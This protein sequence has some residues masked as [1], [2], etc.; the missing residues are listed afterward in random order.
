MSIERDTRQQ[1]AII[2]T[3]AEWK[4]FKVVAESYL[5][6][7]ACLRKKHLR[8]VPTG[9]RLLARNSQKRLLIGVAI[10]QLLKAVYLQKGYCI[11]VL[12]DGSGPLQWPYT[13]AQVQAGGFALNSDK[14]QELNECI[15]QLS[16]NV[17]KLGADREIVLEGLRIAKVYRNK[18]AHIVTSTHHY[19]PMEYRKVEAALKLL[20]LH[21]FNQ[22]LELHFSIS[23]GEKPRFRV[24]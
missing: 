3:Q 22:K 11:N 23:T 15:Q 20:Y 18:E 1:F 14:T 8:G 12:A 9:F 21:A 6:Q 7:A 2:F 10:E 17:L 19:L 24:T 4:Q 13:A 16:E 5:R